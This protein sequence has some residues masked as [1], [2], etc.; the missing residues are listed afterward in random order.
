MENKVVAVKMCLMCLYTIAKWLVEGKLVMRYLAKEINLRSLGPH[1]SLKQ[2][3]T[4]INMATNEKNELKKRLIRNTIVNFL[5]SFQK[6]EDS[7][8]RD[9]VAELFQGLGTQERLYIRWYETFKT[10]LVSIEDIRT[11]VSLHVNGTIKDES[12]ITTTVKFDVTRPY[13]RGVLLPKC[14]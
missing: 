10:G 14:A 7:G 3:D 6:I 5:S 1:V 12:A 4:A 11:L 8:D 13:Q 2:Y 9:M